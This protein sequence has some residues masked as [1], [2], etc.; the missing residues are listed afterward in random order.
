MNK[1][2]KYFI[3]LLVIFHLIGLALFIFAPSFIKL[4]YINISLCGLLVFLDRSITLKGLIAALIVVT[5]G[6]I[7]EL[8]GVQSGLLFGNYTY[9]SALGPKFMEVP[10]IIGVNWLVIVLASIGIIGTLKLGAEIA[11]VIA[12]GLSTAMD[13]L[14][15][16]V[17]IR[18][19][20]WNWY[21]GIVPTWNYV[22]WFIFCT[23]FAYLCIKWW[24]NSNKTG[25][26]LYVIWLLFFGLLNII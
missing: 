26:G 9:G 8:I 14:I 24:G 3:P 16:P 10:L 20:F 21:G 18:Y 22:C 11:A 6:F 5:G 12:G 7:V 4:T 25:A 13:Y 17:A 1:I 19:D 23:I 15:E 2:R